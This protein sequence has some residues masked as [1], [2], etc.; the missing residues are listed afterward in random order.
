MTEINLSK[1]HLVPVG[2]LKLVKSD[3][4]GTYKMKCVAN[5][6]LFAPDIT[7]SEYQTWANKFHP[8]NLGI[9]YKIVTSEGSQEDRYVSVLFAMEDDNKDWYT[10]NKDSKYV[11]QVKKRTSLPI[12]CSNK[13]LQ[14]FLQGSAKLII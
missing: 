9:G 2:N 5:L 6:D 4:Y 14:K 7:T 8:K 13:L 12:A 3:Q 10:N 1:D 11:Q